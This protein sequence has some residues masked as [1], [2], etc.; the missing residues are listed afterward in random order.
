[1]LTLEI[2]PTQKVFSNMVS[3]EANRAKFIKNLFAF[4]RQYAFDGVDFDWVCDFIRFNQLFILA[5]EM[6]LTLDVPGVPRRQR[7]W[8]R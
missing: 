7:P 5:S 8:W 3:T 6:K 2:G 1:M 4:M